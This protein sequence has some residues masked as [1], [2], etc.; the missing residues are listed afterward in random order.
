MKLNSKK[1][2]I[3]TVIAVVSLIIASIALWQTFRHN[4]L[5]VKPYINSHFETILNSAEKY[6][7]N[8]PIAYFKVKHR[9]CWV[10]FCY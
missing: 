9:E 1:V 10:R 8:P 5:S 4:E 2:S 3:S 7:T 6:I